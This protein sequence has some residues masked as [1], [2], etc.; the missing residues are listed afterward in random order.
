M[1][2]FPMVQ[3]SRCQQAFSKPCLANLISKDTHLVFSIYMLIFF[4][5]RTF[6]LFINIIQKEHMPWATATRINKEKTLFA[7][8]VIFHAAGSFFS[9]RLTFT[10]Y[11]LNTVR[12]SNGKDQDQNRRSVG[13]AR[14]P[15]CLQR[16]S[17]NDKSR[18]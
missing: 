18:R 2:V 9:P 5:C 7:C 13:P 16:L 17:T 3:A 12:V 6:I 8:W 1:R 4:P 11:F 14:G 15:K 10:K